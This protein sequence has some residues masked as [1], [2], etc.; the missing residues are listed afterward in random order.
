MF[1][2]AC[3]DIKTNGR[4]RERKRNPRKTMEQQIKQRAV[5]LRY[6]SAKNRTLTEATNMA[7]FSYTKNRHGKAKKQAF[8][9]EGIYKNPFLKFKFAILS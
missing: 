4:N 7:N 2:I 5:I 6:F 8:L 1:I 9:I 3:L